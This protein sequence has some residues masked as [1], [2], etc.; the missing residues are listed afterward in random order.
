[1]ARNRTWVVDNKVEGARGGGSVRIREAFHH[2]EEC[3]AIPRLGY[4]QA[5]Q[6]HAERKRCNRNPRHPVVPLRDCRC[7]GGDHTGRC[8]DRLADVVPRFVSMVERCSTIGPGAA[9]PRAQPM[10][11]GVDVAP[12]DH[13]Q[14]RAARC[15]QDEERDETES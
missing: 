11:V 13:V 5:G 7:R 14:N 6:H 1:M 15:N 9:S 3:D 4:R 2:H 8:D 12:R 10:S